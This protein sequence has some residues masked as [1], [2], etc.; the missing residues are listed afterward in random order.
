V[1]ADGLVEQ[2]LDLVVPVDELLG[3][4]RVRVDERV[5]VTRLRYAT[6]IPGDMSGRYCD[7]CST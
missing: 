4:D 6:N 7:V 3:L 5:D 2:L 1:A